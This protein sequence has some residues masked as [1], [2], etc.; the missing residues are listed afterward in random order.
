MN[1][2]NLKPAVFKNSESLTL[3]EAEGILPTY[4]FE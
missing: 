1:I 3:I 4:D 2:L